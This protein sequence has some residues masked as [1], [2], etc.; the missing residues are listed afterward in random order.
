MLIFH[1]THWFK[2]DKLNCRLT[3]A[4]IT[5]RQ[6]INSL[7][8]LRTGD[9]STNS[10]IWCNFVYTPFWPSEKFGCFY[11]WPVPLCY[12]SMHSNLKEKR[13]ILRDTVNHIQTIHKEK[14]D[15][16]KKNRKGLLTKI[17]NFLHMGKHILC[18]LRYIYQLGINHGKENLF[19]CWKSNGFSKR[20]CLKY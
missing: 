13:Q 5:S 7:W 1:Q 15:R 16:R 4:Q 6:I 2:N 11:I 3:I 20:N 12:Q 17:L 9:P 10:P 18:H 19:Q 8:L 14:G